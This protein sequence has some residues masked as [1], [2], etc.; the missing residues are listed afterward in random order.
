MVLAVVTAVIGIIT[1]GIAVMGY[2]GCQLFLYER[3]IFFIS[4]L[5]LAY[6][7]ISSDGIGLASIVIVLLLYNFRKKRI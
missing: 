3:F 4:A 5:L 6:P 1:L 2:L 7:G